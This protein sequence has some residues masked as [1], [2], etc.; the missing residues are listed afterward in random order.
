MSKKRTQTPST[1]LDSPV[2]TFVVDGNDWSVDLVEAAMLLDTIMENSSNKLKDM[3]PLLIEELKTRYHVVLT[4]SQVYVFIRVIGEQWD[5]FK[6]K[7]NGTQTSP[8]ITK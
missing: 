5:E 1:V 7:F 4:Y 2:I 6:K 3:I 8:T